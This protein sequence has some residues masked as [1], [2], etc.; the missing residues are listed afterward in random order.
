MTPP[1]QYCTGVHVPEGLEHQ[2]L[3]APDG[4]MIN[5]AWLGSGS[6]AAVLLHQTDNNGLCGFLSYAGFLADQQV[7]V[8]AIDMCG[9]SQ[10]FCQLDSLNDPSLQIKLVSDLL[11]EEG[12]E[13]I[14]LVG[15][16]MGGSVA[17]TAGA[18]VQADAIVD[19]SGP[20]DFNTSH[21]STDAPT[22]TMP[23]LI[24]F[25]ETTDPADLAAVKAEFDAMPTTTKKL[26]T[27][28][29]GHGLEL[30]HKQDSEELTP[31]AHQV[32]TWIREA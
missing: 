7:R 9:Y 22:V 24:A 32:L 20:A 26:V 27:V 23:A 16:S 3:T 29:S 13:R 8:V 17:V 30:L 4:S 5:T 31:L 12:A 18:K 2:V 10:S 19:L 21:I 14:T 15:A 28:D 11:R 25:G 6:T 1:A